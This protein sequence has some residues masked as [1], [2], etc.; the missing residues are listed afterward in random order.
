MERKGFEGERDGKSKVR[1][2]D[3]DGIILY[4]YIYI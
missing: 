1:L 3:I 2:E 4:I